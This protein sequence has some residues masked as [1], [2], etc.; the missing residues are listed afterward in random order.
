M[1]VWF[2]E[3][4]VKIKN[5]YYCI[6]NILIFIILFFTIGEAYAAPAVKKVHAKHTYSVSTSEL[7]SFNKYPP[8]VKK[9]IIEALHLA[10]Q[11]LGYNY[12]SAHPKNQGMDC[13]GTVNY[14]LKK[15]QVAGVPRRS[16]EIY[17][18]V[19][20]KGRFHK[21]KGHHF[22]S[23]EFSHLKPGDLLFWSGTYKVKRHIPITHVMLYLGKN[24]SQQPLMF[25]ANSDRGIKRKKIWGVSVFNFKLAPHDLAGRF[26][27]YGCIPSL[28]CGTHKS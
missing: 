4:F 25:G 7:E 27:G 15:L 6:R 20:H 5:R 10:N 8:P 11:N 21:V 28:T 12:G 16:D 14:L 22:N 23:A 9:L 24:K 17:Q 13:S 2:N 3:K 1:S 18:W 19:L 26:V